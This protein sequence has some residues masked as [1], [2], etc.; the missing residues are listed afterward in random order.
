MEP[1]RTDSNLRLRPA[2]INL[3]SKMDSQSLSEI[4][5]DSAVPAANSFVS[6]RN[7]RRPGRECTN[8]DIHIKL[9]DVSDCLGRESRNLI[10][11]AP[12]LQ[13]PSLTKPHKKAS[14]KSDIEHKCL[15]STGRKLRK[16][17]K[18]PNPRSKKG[19]SGRSLFCA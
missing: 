7:V 2:E 14:T 3:I 15:L 11:S 10:L 16:V 17:G 4:S 6:T 8:Q 12:R 13:E 9:L 18:C 19:Q 5:A 1:P